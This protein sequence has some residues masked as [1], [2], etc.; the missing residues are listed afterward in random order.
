VLSIAKLSTEQSPYYVGTAHGRVDSAQSLGG[1]EDY[2]GEAGRAPSAWVG[3]GARHLGLSGPVSDEGLRRAFAGEHP[4]HGELLRARRGPQR[5]AAIDLTFSAPKSVSLLFGL[6]APDIEAS[7]RGAH[8]EAVT[9]AL[10]YLERRAVRVRRGRN[11]MRVLPAEGFVAATF[12]HR[13]SRAGD[14]QLHTHAVVA[15]MGLGPDGRWTALDARPVYAHAMAAGCLYQA[16]LRARLTAELGVTWAPVCDGLAEL[17]GVPTDVLRAF[18]RRRV[19]I[20]AEVAR[21]G[22]SGPTATQAAALATRRRKD[23]NVD[24]EML[25]RD[26]A[27]RAADLGFDP[28]G[29]V[30]RHRSPTLRR[31]QVAAIY[32]YLASSEGLT[33][34]RSS[35][36]APDVV[37]AIASALPAGL[38][39]DVEGIE[40]LAARFLDSDRVVALASSEERRWSTTELLAT[41]RRLVALAQGRRRAGR[42]VADSEALSHAC[43]GRPSL[44]DE[45]RTA[46]RR[47]TSEGD[48]IVVLIG[49]AGAGKT[50]ALR[51][52]A[53]AWRASGA[54]VCGA[55]VARRAARELETGAGIPSTSISALLIQLD[56]RP[57]Q[58]GTVLVVD[59]AGMTGTRALAAL[60]EA[61]DA[62]DGKLVLVGDDRQ[63]EA[64]DAGGAFRA[65]ARRGP[66]IQLTQ[67]RR[68]VH[69]WERDAAAALRDGD[70]RAALVAYARHDR[71]TVTHRDEEA[72]QRLISDWIAQGATEDVVMLAHR[73]RDVADLNL[74]ARRHLRIASRLGIEEARCAAGRIATGD[75]LIVRQN[76]PSHDLANGDRGTVR[77]VDRRGRVVL[78]VRDTTVE[79]GAD[80]LLGR[81][82]R[83]EPVLQY[84]YALT[85]HSAQGL[86]ARRALVL[87][88]PGVGRDWL[89]TAMTRGRDA[90]Q[91][92]LVARL[93]RDRDEFGPS[94]RAQP[95][96]IE[97]L[98]A[99]LERYQSQ[100]LALDQLP[101]RAGRSW[102]ARGRSDLER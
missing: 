19:E 36:A 81:T 18:S 73:R 97:A 49:V 96:A 83:G 95:D 70:P 41:E 14:P 1:A 62:A 32:D 5:N 45:Q 9:A 78:D 90:N 99:Q 25:R 39:I 8:D 58:T 76:L 7:V 86:T 23:R 101:L 43:L 30:G 28:A 3:A 40:T 33:A 29:V 60:A 6:G 52:C 82:H 50:F 34:R 53:D 42:G 102:P 98:A 80:V 31:T 51:T 16:A 66:S 54:P 92:Y 26:W 77:S 69:G 46:V 94:A 88:D 27:R 17:D 4:L 22:T 75:V 11:G 57:L 67:N 13:A 48:G 12:R 68:Q 10:G 85:G 93:D 56:D 72:R 59:E 61:V 15:N 65:L 37:G 91:L 24:A 35:F 47:L 63:L 84:G 87:A 55:A 64:I 79:L 21:H 2:Y 100:E 20:E 44:T 38:D 89:Y 71:I 74:R